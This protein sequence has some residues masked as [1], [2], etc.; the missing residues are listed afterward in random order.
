MD[1]T[2]G[3]APSI[4]EEETINKMTEKYRL[5]YKK[6]NFYIYKKFGEGAVCLK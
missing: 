3:F 2:D 4:G 1:F 6:E 5:I